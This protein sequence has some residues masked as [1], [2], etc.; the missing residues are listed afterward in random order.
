M[1]YKDEELRKDISEIKSDITILKVSVDCIAQYLCL[2]NSS[3]TS[4]LDNNAQEL[5]DRLIPNTENAKNQSEISEEESADIDF[6]LVDPSLTD[7]QEIREALIRYNKDLRSCK[8]RKEFLQFCSTLNTLVEGLVKHFIKQKFQELLE[9]N[10]DIIEGYE[11]VEENLR[12]GIQDSM[13]VSEEIRSKTY[14]NIKDRDK[15]LYFN[16]DRGEYLS[17]VCLQRAELKFLFELCCAALYKS[18]FYAQKNRSQNDRFK[19]DSQTR[20]LNRVF[21]K[22]TKKADITGIRFELKYYYKLCNARIFRNAFM[23]NP[24]D[25]SAQQDYLEDQCKIFQHLKNDLNNYDDMQ[26]A[27][28]WFIHQFALS[29]NSAGNSLHKG[30]T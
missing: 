13:Y 5:P 29:Q 4:K 1:E 30:S 23:H 11:L 18:S 28:Q 20:P 26:K 12:Y 3:Q 8:E 25:K 6:F 24:I 14:Q 17:L 10:Q 19:T 22:P 21:E 15:K 9:G 7:N 2:E 27:A 16:P